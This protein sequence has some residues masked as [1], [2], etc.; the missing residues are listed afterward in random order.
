[1]IADGAGDGTGALGIHRAPTVL[2]SARYSLHIAASVLIA[3]PLRFGT[4]P[5]VY[6][7]PPLGAAATLA[8]VE[9]AGLWYGPRMNARP[10]VLC[11]CATVVSA[12]WYLAAN[13]GDRLGTEL[14][15]AFT[16]AR[17]A[18]I[19]GGVQLD[20]P[21]GERRKLQTLL[22]ARRGV[23]GFGVPPAQARCPLRSPLT[24]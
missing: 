8:G 15:L 4:T 9:T 18:P 20:L 1:M 24:M 22:L 6:D 19:P 10:L 14:A 21:A 23:S 12:A 17:Q 7:L 16:A 2:R 13:A 5:R 3:I 11:S